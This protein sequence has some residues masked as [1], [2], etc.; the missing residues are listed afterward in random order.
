MDHCFVGHG[1]IIQDSDSPL[2]VVPVYY[3]QRLTAAATDDSITSFTYDYSLT[4][5]IAA[6]V[7]DPNV[8]NQVYTRLAT[9]NWSYVVNETFTGTN[10][11]GTTGVNHIVIANPENWSP[12][13]DGS[14]ENAF[15][16]V[17]YA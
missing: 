5:D 11:T 4:L 14:T 12:V 15:N 10:G 7:N 1:G 17:R 16:P 3:S 2:G 9:K 13:E 6:Y 8:R